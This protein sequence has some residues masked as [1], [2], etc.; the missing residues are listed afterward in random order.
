MGSAPV[1]GGAE[2]SWPMSIKIRNMVRDDID[3]ALEI[4]R[5]HVDEHAKIAARD[6]EEFFAKPPTEHHQY[7]VAEVDGK[8][9]GCMGFLPDK[10]EEVEGVYWAVWLYVHPE[11]RRQGVGTQ[12]W[13]E[14]EERLKKLRARKV[15]LDV[16]NEPDHPEAIAFHQK[17]GFVKEGELIDYFRDGENMLIFGKRLEY[18]GN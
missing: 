3:I 11:Y 16:G 7:L 14:I 5:S 13:T 10:D 2:V 18:E 15:Y 17:H 9:V 8:V 1:I 12:L 4:I 6:F